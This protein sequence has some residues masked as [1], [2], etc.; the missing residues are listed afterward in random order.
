[1]PRSRTFIEEAN[2]KQQLREAA[3]EQR[4]YNVGDTIGP[5]RVDD[6]DIDAE[7]HMIMERYLNGE[8]TINDMV[9]ILRAPRP[10]KLTPAE[11]V[12]RN[13]LLREAEREQRASGVRSALG[14]LAIAG[15]KIDAQTQA[16]MDRYIEGE[17]SIDELMPAI[18][19]LDGKP[20]DAG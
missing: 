3:R 16:V 18:F 9:D 7:T 10:R 11:E 5:F 20:C 19:A 8:L 6:L 17:L 14:S 15:L 2:R 13:V 4:R 1:M 12:N